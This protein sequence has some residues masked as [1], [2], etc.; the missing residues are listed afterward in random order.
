MGPDRQQEVP[1]HSPAVAK[2]G[3]RL[4]RWLVE[5]ALVLAMFAAIHF[6]QVRAVPFGAAPALAGTAV[7]GPYASLADLRAAHPGRAV[8]VHVWAEWCRICSLEEGNVTALN[9]KLPLLTLAMQSGDAGAVAR[10]LRE[11][12]LDWPT[13]VVDPDGELARR[14]GVVAVPALIVIDPVGRIRFAEIGYTSYFGMRWR[15]WWA[16]RV[17]R[18]S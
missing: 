18:A 4:R 12:G 16:E 1:G 3:R 7:N 14:L 11:R 13:L 10:A 2:G 5:L 9:G 17:S 8:A 15:H 6:W